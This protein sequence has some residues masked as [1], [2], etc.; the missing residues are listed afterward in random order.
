MRFSSLSRR[1]ISILLIAALL[2]L[3][4][5]PATAM[6]GIAGTSEIVAEENASMDRDQLLETLQ[7]DEVRGELERFGVNPADAMERVAAMTDQE[8]RELTHGLEA[9]PA[10]AGV[11]LV[12]VIVLLILVLR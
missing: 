6:A 9:Q 7:R 11:V 3:S 1:P 2:M 8:V 5:L 10:G 4:F 12:L